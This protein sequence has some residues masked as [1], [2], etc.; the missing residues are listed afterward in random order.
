MKTVTLP[1][2]FVVLQRLL[3]SRLAGFRSWR[4]QVTANGIDGHVTNRG[5]IRPPTAI[6]V[7]G[8]AGFDILLAIADTVR[9]MNDALGLCQN[10][11]RRSLPEP[12]SVGPILSVL[13]T[14][15][16]WLF[17]GLAIAGYAALFV[18]AVGGVD[19]DGFRKEWGVWVWIATNTF[20][21]LAI[22]RSVDAIVAEYRVRSRQRETRRILRF[23]VLQR[24]CWWHLAKQKDGSFLS[25][26]TIDVQATNTTDRP[27]QIVRLRLVRPKAVVIQADALLPAED[28][29]YHSHQHPIPPHGTLAVPTHIMARGAL[30]A[31]GKPIRVTLAITDQYGE[32]YKIKNIVVGTHDAP[33][34]R[35]TLA[36]LF[37]NLLVRKRLGRNAA[38]LAPPIPWTFSN[39]NYLQATEN[40][41]NEEKRNYAANGRFRGGLGSLN[42]KIQSELNLGW[43]IEGQI[44]ELLWTREKATPLS[45]PNLARLLKLHTLLGTQDQDNLQ[46]FLL[47]QLR[48][49]SPYSEIGYFVFLALHRMGRTIDALRT[50][51]TF[52]AGD[53]NDGYSNLLATLSAIVSHE[54]FDI[55]PPLYQAIEEALAGDEEHDFGLRQKIN[56]ARLE[57][58]DRQSDK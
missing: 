20:L 15:P 21:V 26:I 41:L 47:S 27:V 23:V 42:V 56:R 10:C 31:A 35:R 25:Q 39:A 17:F 18:P 50:A 24:Q 48:K 6:A 28:S 30:A 8:W 44:P 49:D 51:R 12:S 54:H 52:L 58:L 3:A 45:S 4:R 2:P 9:L 11:R 1:L 32:D 46:H 16:I 19:L 14:L 34:P 43:T 33:A 55:E 22:A 53:K 7:A 40:I 38:P 37:R 57:Y 36:A 5:D 13:R 29:P